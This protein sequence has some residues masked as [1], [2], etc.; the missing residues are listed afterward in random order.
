MNSAPDNQIRTCFVVM[1]FAVEFKNQWELAVAPAIADAGL[2]PVRGDDS[3]LAAGAIMSDVTRLIYGSTL[4]V[5]DL[6]GKNPNVMYELGLAHSAQKPVVMLA[7]RDADVP[8]DLSHVR[9][10]KYDV[11]DLSALRR[12]L[13]ERIK[14]TLSIPVSGLQRFF[15]EL[16]IMRPDDVEN[17]RYLRQRACRITV[18]AYPPTADVFFN[19]KYIGKTPQTITVNPE[20]TRNS[21]SFFAIDFFEDHHEITA[22]DITKGTIDV[23]LQP[24]RYVDLMEHV[25]KWLR[26]RRQYPMNPVFIGAVLNFLVNVSKIEDATAEA[27]ELLEIAP[28]WYGAWNNAGWVAYRHDSNLGKSFFRRVIALAP[29]HYVGYF[30]MA[31]AHSMCGELAEALANLKEMLSDS[32]RLASLIAGNENVSSVFEDCDL[33]NLMSAPEFKDQIDETRKQLDEFAESIRR[34]ESPLPTFQQQS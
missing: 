32:Q 11:Q 3:S 13:T 1:P 30:N 9:Y 34:V 25:P 29:D 16:E 23:V 8:F 28:G 27:N 19:D 5:A 31:C 21:V 10:L 14:A 12:N 24:R 17:L 20:A 7:Q 4:I 2:V 22:D 15:P 26:L 18:N 6:S 33:G